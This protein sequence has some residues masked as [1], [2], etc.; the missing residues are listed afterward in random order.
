LYG[1]NYIKKTETQP[2]RYEINEEQTRV[3]KMI[4]EWFGIEGVSKNEIIKRLFDQ[5]I[6]PRKNK[7]QFWT[8]GPLDRVLKCESYV[9]GIVYYNKSEAV[10]AKH[11][12]KNEKYR[13]VKK[14]S[15]KVR[16]KDE[17]L[18]FEVPKLIDN[19]ALFEKIQERL[20]HNKRFACKK[21]KYQY[22]LSGLTYCECGNRRVG[23]GIDKNNFYYRCAERI[24]K[25]PMKKKCNSKGFNA[26][27]L[28]GVFWKE[29]LNFLTN[30]DKLK[31]STLKWLT[32]Q[33]NNG[34]AHAELA[35]LDE[36]IAKAGEEETRYAKAYGAGSLDF[37][38]FR[39]LAKDVKKRKEGYISQRAE[40]N[41]KLTQESL[42]NVEVD[43][44]VFEAE[45]V[46]KTLD[47]NNKFQVVR[48]II[49]KVI[50]EGGGIVKVKG[51]LPLFTLN[52]GYESIS[53]NCWASKRR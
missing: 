11:P 41:K 20:E 38:Q 14:N 30:P 18:P 40:L 28:D 15:R 46:I 44:I 19:Y 1:W 52:M 24:Y 9:S 8:K 34:A 29:L 31:E 6:P 53:R 4:W 10:I 39:D 7:S 26:V 37:E 12:I 13:K 17:W 3:V 25:F 23:D 45:K 48:D 21:R 51:R 5:G 43:K 22:L 47:L 35:K 36:F 33:V 32:A 50:M 2:A 27:V 49:T 42:E 16:I